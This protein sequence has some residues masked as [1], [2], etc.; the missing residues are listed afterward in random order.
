MRRIVLDQ[1]LPATA[2]PILRTAA[3]DSIHVRE[4]NMHADSDA[5]ILVYAARESRVVITLDR[6]FPKS[7]RT[8]G[9]ARPSI[10]LIRR[11]RLRAPELIE[12]L[13]SIWN[14]YE[15]EL[16][17]GCVVTCGVR[18]TRLRTLPIK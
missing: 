5:E 3:W 13:T 14:Q 16:D 7:R 4:I 2:A 12:I 11:Q 9:A 15:A 17:E 8:W 10:V 6:D 1:G 18:G